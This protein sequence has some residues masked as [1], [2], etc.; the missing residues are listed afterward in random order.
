MGYSMDA[1]EFIKYA[2]ENMC[3]C[4][5]EYV[6]YRT[7]RENTVDSECGQGK[8]VSEREKERKT[9]TADIVLVT[10]TSSSRST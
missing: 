6:A 5:I 7:R 1:I 3:V 9:H 10:N 4:L 8:R 2:Y